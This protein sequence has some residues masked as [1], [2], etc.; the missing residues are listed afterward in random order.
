MSLLARRKHPAFDEEI[1]LMRSSSGNHASTAIDPQ[2]KRKHRT[3]MQAGFLIVGLFV[4][5]GL[6]LGNFLLHHQHR[7][8]ILH[9]MRNPWAHGRAALRIAATRKRPTSDGFHHHFYSGSPR[10]VT[11]VMPSVVNP[12]H[13]RE[14]LEAIH[15]TWGPYA[16]AI[17]VLHDLSEFPKASHLTMAEDVTPSDRY[18]YPQNLLLPSK[19]RAEDGVPR[20]Y[21]VIKVL[22]SRVDPDY[23][24]FV[25]DHTFVIPGHL[26][27]WLEDKDPRTDL[28]AG[29]A[30]KSDQTIFNSGAAGYLLS[31]ETMRKL[32]QKYD[33]KDPQCWISDVA[34]NKKWLQG[35]PLLVVNDCLK[36]MGIT[37]IDTRYMNKYHR[38][39]AF[40]LTR[41]VSGNVDDWYTKKHQFDELPDDVRKGFDR[42]YSTLLTGDECCSSDSV[43]FHYVENHECRALFSV[44]YHLL[45]HPLLSDAEL[46]DLIRRLWPSTQKEIGGYSRG[47]PEK[48]NQEAWAALLKTVRK[49][50]TKETQREC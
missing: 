11:V 2:D 40:P 48:D 15:D 12:G 36:S 31:R 25:N 20:L 17:Y 44:Q 22:F 13:R 14:R 33:D 28:Y 47:L 7:K 23:A 5:V 6:L 18:A 46:G 26:C 21:H 37:A 4:M 43:S 30:L 50:T 38:F 35:N 49:I 19:M 45:E 16:R 42:S 10:F 27:S 3:E 29:H 41:L 8:V 34:K 24:F 1:L 39:H 32:L 9:V